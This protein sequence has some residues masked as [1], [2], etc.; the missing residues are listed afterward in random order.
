MQVTEEIVPL[1]QGTV[2]PNRQEAATALTQLHGTHDISDARA[3][4]APV[5]RSEAVQSKESLAVEVMHSHPSR[6]GLEDLSGYLQAAGDSEVLSTPSMNSSNVIDKEALAKAVASSLM[7]TQRSSH[8]MRA[9][10][11]SADEDNDGR[12]NRRQL[13]FALRR[14]PQLCSALNLPSAMRLDDGQWVDM[15]ERALSVTTGGSA[16]GAP[17]RSYSFVDFVSV[18]GQVMGVATA[19][20]STSRSSSSMDQLPVPAAKSRRK[21]RKGAGQWS[22]SGAGSPD[23]DIGGST[24]RSRSRR[25]NLKATTRYGKS[26]LWVGSGPNG[27]ASTK[28]VASIEQCIRHRLGV[29]LMIHLRWLRRTQASGAM[30]VALTHRVPLGRS[31]CSRREFGT[32]PRASS[33]VLGDEH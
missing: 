19:A 23:M 2:S 11:D 17:Q 30:A 14:Q 32:R 9:L 25:T 4:A 29:V 21:R 13:L 18:M 1:E 33:C 12:V 27:L 10:F 22:K 7:S 5:E 26:A 15:L 8:A 16:G 20:I 24:G 6:H 31:W 3:K 28:E